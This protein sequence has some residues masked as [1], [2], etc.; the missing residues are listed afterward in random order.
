MIVYTGGTFD[1][2]HPGHVHLLSRCRALAGSHGQVVVSV[3]TDE[4]VESYKGRRPVMSFN[5]RC[6]VLAAL[7]DVDRVIENTGG[8]D[9]K[10]A[11]EQV[12]PDIIAIGADWAP[13]TG[14]D[15]MAQ[16]QFTEAWLKEFGIA[17]VFVPL[18]PDRSSTRLR[19]NAR[20]NIH[21]RMG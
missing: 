20:A 16:M 1:L 12:G 8:A 15:Y 6:I 7:R 9:S 13:E 11:I 18:L 10:P 17:L 4:F 3:N 5:D 2:I 19:N 21:R 14:K